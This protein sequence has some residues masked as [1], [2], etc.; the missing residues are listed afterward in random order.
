MSSDS[1]IPPAA[2]AAHIDCS[3]SANVATPAVAPPTRG[4]KKDKKPPAAPS[5]KNPQVDHMELLDKLLKELERQIALKTRVVMS[6]DEIS[7]LFLK[8][9]AL[10]VKAL[11]ESGYTGGIDETM[12]SPLKFKPK[13]PV[14]E[15]AK[16][17]T[18]LDNFETDEQKV[19]FVKASV[20]PKL[21]GKFCIATFPKFFPERLVNYM[22][23]V[24]L[25]RINENTFVMTA[26]RNPNADGRTRDAFVNEKPVG[27]NIIIINCVVRH[28]INEATI[29]DDLLHYAVIAIVNSH[30]N[31]KHIELTMQADTHATRA[32]SFNPDEMTLEEYLEARRHQM[33]GTVRTD[34]HGN[35]FMSLF[36]VAG[37]DAGC[38]IAMIPLVINKEHLNWNTMTPK[39]RTLWK[40]RILAACRRAIPRASGSK[41]ENLG[42][43]K[44]IPNRTRQLDSFWDLANK[45]GGCDFDNKK[46]CSKFA[47]L[48][49]SMSCTV[50]IEEG[51]EPI[52]AY[53]LVVDAMSSRE[54]FTIIE[55]YTKEEMCMLYCIFP[56]GGTPGGSGNHFADFVRSLKSGRLSVAVHTG[57]RGWGHKLIKLLKSIL[58]TYGNGHIYAEGPFADFA[59]K[60]G[61][62]LVKFA[63]IN[64]M[65]IMANVIEEIQGS[66]INFVEIFENA[67]PEEGMTR[68]HLANM[69]IGMVHNETVYYANDQT[70]QICQIEKKGATI[71]D[72]NDVAII[73]GG[74]RVPAILSAFRKHDPSTKI[75][76]V[77]ISSDDYQLKL[78][79]GY[80]P[81]LHTETTLYSGP[82]GTGRE[83]TAR[84]TQKKNTDPIIPGVQRD[85]TLE[86][87]KKEIKHECIYN[88]APGHLSDYG[89][90]R[91]P[92]MIIKHLL[93]H[94]MT[95]YIAYELVVNFK[96]ANE[97]FNLFCQMG[98]QQTSRLYPMFKSFS[99]HID[100]YWIP[101]RDHLKPMT[102]D[103]IDQFMDSDSFAI[104]DLV[105]SGKHWLKYFYMIDVVQ[106][107]ATYPGDSYKT[108]D[109]E[110]MQPFNAI[111]QNI[112]KMSDRYIQPRGGQ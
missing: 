10:I 38:G 4:G 102:V 103:E 23:N 107:S 86:F 104:E 16:F 21:P 64:R 97:D 60:I 33:V 57:C 44:D 9:N 63:Q 20:G 70:Q 35:V 69:M 62:F 61:E 87:I 27:G 3:V 41:T 106:R 22:Y 67:E 84:A 43:C 11:K 47:D 30:I 108:C 29:K 88:S 73:A 17:L 28:K 68:A 78:S 93:D 100:K 53:Q 80:L 111:H 34:L 98:R 54:D 31:T 77:K 37:Q 1:K 65:I 109:E 75:E 50:P 49:K 32:L 8:Y 36:E 48:L 24:F 56:L 55:P 91:P 72:E 46:L 58:V 18:K 45:H 90:Y 5:P 12:S 42:K 59:A 94:G 2:S 92:E 99:D 13:D 66:P 96:E 76:W 52:N 15:L 110:I 39:Q 112:D 71:Q 19:E 101:L 51:V 81:V 74:A 40:C 26:Q 14:V 82:H 79:Q 85:F 89:G 95:G 105:L 83:A 6:S 7:E 25:E